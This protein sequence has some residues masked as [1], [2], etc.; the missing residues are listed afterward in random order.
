MD[1]ALDALAARIRVAAAAGAA[2]RIR[3]GG[4][5]DFYG[6]PL[7]GDVLDTQVYAGIIDYEPT[8]LVITARAGTSLAAVESAMRARGQMLAFEPPHY[9]P[10][11]TLG[12]AVASGLSGPRRPYAGAVRDLVLGVKVLDGAGEHLSF[13]GRVMKN[14]AGF[15]VSRLMTGALGTLGVITEVS[16]K[17]LPLPRDETTVAFECSADEA[18]RRGNEWSGQPL[19]LSATCFH[20]G[21][22]AVRLSGALPAVQAAAL[23]LGGEPVADGDALWA[24]VRD[25]S[26]RFFTAAAKAG[27]PLWRLSVKSTAPYSDLGG[28]QLIEWGGAL[29]WLAA[30]ERV[31]SAK[32]RAWAVAQGGHA[33]QFR[34]PETAKAANVFQ[35][36]DETMTA[37]HRKLKAVFDPKGVFNRGRLAPDF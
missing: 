27:K 24:S 30:G 5:K 12:G 13:G 21:R 16:L 2:L 1:P 8:E 33:T 9:A 36:L 34:S 29:R 20:D 31:E 35:P 17:C 28:D 11:G 7:T 19:P 32:L 3:G 14:V 15:D 26:H 23:K 10:G 6:G 18:I 4:T 37:L 25:Q 22:L